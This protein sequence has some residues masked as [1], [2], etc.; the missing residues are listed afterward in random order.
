MEKS[1]ND[2]VT[3]W[4][5]TG[6]NKII[7]PGYGKYR[8]DWGD[9]TVE[10]I[11]NSQPRSFILSD[12]DIVNHV[13]TASGEYEVRVSNSIKSFWLNDCNKPERLLEVKQWGTAEWATMCCA[14]MHGVNLEIT[15]T[16]VPDLSD[17]INMGHMLYGAHK[18]N[19]YIDNWDTSNVT[20]TA[21]A[22][23]G[24]RS[25]NQKIG[26]WDMGCVTNA[27][28]M[29]ASTTVFNQKIGNWDT[30]NV[31]TMAGM[32]AYACAFNQKIGKWNTSNVT[33]MV[34]MLYGASS[35]NQKIDNWD[36]SNVIDMTGILAGASSFKYG[37]KKWRI[38]R[39]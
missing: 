19:S 3:V 20:N 4:K 22:F 38:D 24:A 28:F 14:F 9:G 32:L 30:G 34:R 12:C 25:F 21:H 31:T 1:K 26:S 8:I 15:A 11:D 6:D 7:F 29:L 27:E 16:D 39:K 18:F 37:T 13:Y 36:T 35:F 33:T 5:I 17:V 23:H 10:E 2:F